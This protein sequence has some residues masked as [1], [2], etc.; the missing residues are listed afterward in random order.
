[1]LSAAVCALNML[2]WLRQLCTVS[3]L[4]SFSRL[5]RSLR[6][7]GVTILIVEHD[8]DFV[9]KLCPRVICM[10]EGTVLAHGTPAQVQGNA[11]VLEAYLGN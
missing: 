5:L 11:A 2:M 4:Q 3:P 1:M 6:G 8:M 9:M 10:V 7:E